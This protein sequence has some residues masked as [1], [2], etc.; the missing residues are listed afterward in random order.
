MALDYIEAFE[1]MI[2]RRNIA[3]LLR[4][5]V[6]RDLEIETMFSNFRL[7]RAHGEPSKRQIILGECRFTLLF[8]PN[9]HHAE[10]IVVRRGED[11][12]GTLQRWRSG[13]W[14]MIGPEQNIPDREQALACISAI[15]DLAVDDWKCR[16][17]QPATNPG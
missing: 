3:R 5:E 8:P 11:V 14:A 17:M 1:R 4:R 15:R 7:D 16:S 9:E 10:S 13:Q 2:R 6:S 12:L